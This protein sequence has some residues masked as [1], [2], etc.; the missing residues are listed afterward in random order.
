MTSLVL[1]SFIF[2]LLSPIH[3]RSFIHIFQCFLLIPRLFI[4]VRSKS[5]YDCKPSAYM[6]AET[7]R[8]GDAMEWTSVHNELERLSLLE[9]QNGEKHALED[10]PSMVTAR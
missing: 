3:E 5:V 9:W 8:N 1:S 6:Y 2:S 10:I 4:D 7:V